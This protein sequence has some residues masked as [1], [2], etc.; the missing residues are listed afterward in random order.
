MII[1][2]ANLDDVE[3]IVSLD[4]EVLQTNWHEKL[5]A[6]SIV[7]KDTQ[8][9]VLDH[10]GRLI[11]FLIYR[12]IGG[13]F[14]IIQLAL[15]KAYQRQGLASMMIDYMIQDAQSSHIEFIYL[16]V[17]MDNLPALNLYKKYGFE[18]IHQRKNYY[19]QGQDA[20]VMRKEMSNVFTS[21]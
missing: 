10:E 5:Y 20:I 12:N 7:L 8:S 2:K 21:N 16:E 14:E 15:N 17:E 9:L 18:A 1:R 13:D 3:A 11:G 6:E 19:G 4:Q